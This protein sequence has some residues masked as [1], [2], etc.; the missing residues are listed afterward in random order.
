MSKELE[1]YKKTK[2]D[3]QCKTCKY[4]DECIGTI[5]EAIYEDNPNSN[6]DWKPDNG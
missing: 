3:Y 1:E 4:V 5:Y 6:D 2:C